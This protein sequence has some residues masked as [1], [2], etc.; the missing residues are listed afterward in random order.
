MEFIEASQA[1]DAA[2]AEIRR[3]EITDDPLFVP[4]VEHSLGEPVLVRDLSRQ[5]SYW[6][7]P[8]VIANGLCREHTH[9]KFLR[10]T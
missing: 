1:L 4:W 6:L 7:V 3:L 10:G 8:V 2:G 5:P 9:V